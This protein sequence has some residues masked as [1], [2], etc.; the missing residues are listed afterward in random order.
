MSTLAHDI[1]C[2]KHFVLFR[3][4]RHAARTSPVFTKGNLMPISPVAFSK[5]VYYGR[6]AK[7]RAAMEAKGI[8]VLFATHSS[9][10][11]LLSG[12]D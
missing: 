2:L 1:E 6:I 10:Q 12:Y 5:T 8:D 7:T 9:N 3:V 11:T 4:L